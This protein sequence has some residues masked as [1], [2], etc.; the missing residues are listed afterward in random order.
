MVWVVVK[1]RAPRRSYPSGV[2]VASASLGCGNASKAHEDKNR[3][4]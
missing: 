4:A 3:A 1:S 2:M